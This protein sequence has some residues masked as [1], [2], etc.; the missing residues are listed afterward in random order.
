MH[1]KKIDIKSQIAFSL[2]NKTLAHAKFS[3]LL[4]VDLTVGDYCPFEEKVLEKVL[5]N[6][7][8]LEKFLNG[9]D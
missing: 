3:L 1:S 4:K 8:F 5:K 9:F 6:R 2:I 7:T